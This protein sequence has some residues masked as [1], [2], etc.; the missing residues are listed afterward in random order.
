MLSQMVRGVGNI[1]DSIDNCENFILIS[2]SNSRQFLSW[3]RY[4][5]I[6]R[7][8]SVGALEVRTAVEYKGYDNH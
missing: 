7:K 3:I 2:V 4:L 6:H 8:S 1:N 5:P